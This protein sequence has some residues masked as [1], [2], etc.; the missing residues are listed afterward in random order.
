VLEVLYGSGVR[1]GELCGLDIDSLDLG[2]AAVTVWGKGA[3]ERRVPLSAPAVEALRAWLAIRADV[4]FYRVWETADAV[5]IVVKSNAAEEIRVVRPDR[6]DAIERVR[7]LGWWVV[8]KK[9]EHRPGDKLV[10][11]EIDS[12]YTEAHPRA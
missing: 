6:I 7:V 5:I 11:C 8:A 3:K 1:V 12:V 10:Y 2:G 9:G 4:R